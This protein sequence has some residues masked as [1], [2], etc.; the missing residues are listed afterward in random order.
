MLARCG[1]EAQFAMRVLHHLP[2]FHMAHLIERVPPAGR[3]N[4]IG[5][6]AKIISAAALDHPISVGLAPQA[7]VHAERHRDSGFELQIV[8]HG[9]DWYRR[10]DEIEVITLMPA[11]EQKH[12]LRF[13]PRLVDIDSDL[14][15][16][17]DG[18]AQRLEHGLFLALI[19]SDL[20]VIGPVA[21]LDTVLCLPLDVFRRSPFY[22]IVVIDAVAHGTAEHAI[23]R[24]PAF[25]SA[26]IPKGH[27]DPGES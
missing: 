18:A 25:L 16:T 6:I 15:R 2:A 13:G 20:D 10:L 9:I 7:F 22:V 24:L 4:P 23:E 19:R 21:A 5:A 11:L 26:Q 14:A 1:G 27:V 8:L 3:P 17:T 12:R